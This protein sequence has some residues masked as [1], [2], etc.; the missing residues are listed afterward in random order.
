MIIGRGLRRHRI[1][2]GKSSTAAQV[3]RLG[4]PITPVDQM[5]A[6]EILGKRRQG[7]PPIAVVAVENAVNLAVPPPCGYHHDDAIAA[8]PACLFGH[9]ALEIG[10]EV[11]RVLNLVF[12]YC[13]I[14]QYGSPKRSRIDLASD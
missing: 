11:D 2:N 1:A 14:D 8:P 12:K 4:E 5:V 13:D 9:H 10:N 6:V 3:H 7:S